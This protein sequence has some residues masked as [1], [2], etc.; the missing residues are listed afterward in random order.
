MNGSTY[1]L[2]HGK[3]HVTIAIRTNETMST[4]DFK[5]K[6]RWIIDSCKRDDP[7]Y[8]FFD[9]GLIEMLNEIYEQLPIERYWFVCDR[10]T[11]YE[12]KRKQKAFGFKIDK[13]A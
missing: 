9:D 1:Y 12:L 10:K 8:Y 11:Y 3:Y 5:E 2:G 13:V 7:E 6:I 4:E